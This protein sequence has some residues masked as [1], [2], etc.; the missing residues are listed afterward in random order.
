MFSLKSSCVLRQ[1]DVLEG[2]ELFEYETLSYEKD[3]L[4]FTFGC[5]LYELRH[6]E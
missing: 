3:C 4:C 1:W 6:E 5:N 2:H